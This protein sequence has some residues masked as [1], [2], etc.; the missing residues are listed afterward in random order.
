MVNEQ[1]SGKTKGQIKKKP[2]YF[3]HEREI[4]VRFDFYLA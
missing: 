4:Q 1:K 3:G 2:F